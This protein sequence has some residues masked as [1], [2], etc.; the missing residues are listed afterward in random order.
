MKEIFM[1][2]SNQVSNQGIFIKNI[3]FKCISEVLVTPQQQYSLEDQSQK[4]QKVQ[5]TQA[6]GF[7]H[8]S[9]FSL[10]FSFAFQTQNLFSKPVQGLFLFFPNTNIKY[11]YQKL[12]TKGAQRNK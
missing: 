1:Y 6:S 7:Q 12:G 10:K 3:T 8:R 4:A 5:T 11:L 2:S 9:I